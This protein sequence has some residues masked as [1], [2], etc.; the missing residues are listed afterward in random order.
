MADTSVLTTRAKCLSL[1]DA[2]HWSISGVSMVSQLGEL[3][4]AIRF[5]NPTDIEFGI[6]ALTQNRPRHPSSSYEHDGLRS[7]LP[8]VSTEDISLRELS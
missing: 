6:K 3:H 4:N 7:P 8:T 1:R 2:L 5:T